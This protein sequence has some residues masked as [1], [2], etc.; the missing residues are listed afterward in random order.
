[1]IEAPGI[2]N[3]KGWLKIGFCGNRPSIGESYISTGSLYLC[4]P[5][6][7]PLGLPESDPFWTDTQADW[8]SKK[9]WKGF[10]TPADHAISI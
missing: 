6:L 1:M 7:L 2:F 8:G 4:S 9:V 3:E 5:G 10:D